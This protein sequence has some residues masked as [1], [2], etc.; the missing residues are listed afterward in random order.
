M[1]FFRQF[2]SIPY[3]TSTT[4]FTAI[5]LSTRR[6]DFLAKGSDGAPIF[7]LHDAST[8]QYC[9]GVQFRHLNAQFHATCHVHSDGTDLQDQFALVS[10]DNSVPDLHEIFIRCFGA[11]IEELPDTC[12]TKEL[13]S[14][15]QR[16]LD[17]FRVLSQP[18][19]QDVSG[20]WA[21]LFVIAN[22]SNVS[23]ALARW[24]EDQFD[25][26]DFSWKQGCIEVKS[27]TRAVRVHEFSLEQLVVPINGVGFVVSLLLQPL[28]G[29]A[30]VLDLA[31]SID[32]EVRHSSALK[33]KLWKNVAKA[34]GSDF[35]D[36]LDKR[37]DVSYAERH[38]S[39]YSMDDVPRPDQPKDPRITS[40]R[41]AVDLTDVTSSL[42]KLSSPPHVLRDI[43]TAPI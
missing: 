17:L 12:S 31:N 13:N 30:G 19:A 6:K 3:A 7:L 24:H 2:S 39:V 26:F 16:L 18:S 43:F 4:N 41:F 38:I 42:S 21:E 15:I 33:Q 36:K 22:S 35:S 14:C 28:S 37:F 27:S 20:L 11:A 8:A 34:L 23:H 40:I 10:C 9:P 25:R 5:P 1:D 32:I 29:G